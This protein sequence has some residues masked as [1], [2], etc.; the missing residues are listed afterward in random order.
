LA[1]L[2][3]SLCRSEEAEFSAAAGEPVAQQASLPGVLS[4]LERDVPPV[5]LPGVLL[6]LEL[7]VPPVSL[8][9]RD[10]QVLDAL[11]ARAVPALVSLLALRRAAPQA[12]HSVFH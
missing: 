5:W 3:S 9:E 8:Q 7:A 10:S 11:L 6:V 2:S 1:V 4:V 12:W